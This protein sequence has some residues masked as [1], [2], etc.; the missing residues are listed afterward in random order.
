MDHILYPLNSSVAQLQVPFLCDG[1]AEYDA[2]PFTTYPIRKGW[3]RVTGDLLWLQCADEELAKRSQ[4]WLYFG[5]LSSFCGHV[6]PRAMLRESDPSTGSIRL[7]TKH[8]PLIL[9]TWN[10]QNKFGA[11]LKVLRT[12]LMEAWRLS[13]LVEGRVTSRQ[14][15]LPQISCSVRILLETLNSTNGLQLKTVSPTRR[16]VIGSIWPFEF[17]TGLIHGWKIPAAKAIKYRMDERGWCP[18]RVTDFS[19][20]FAGSTLH[21]LSGLPLSIQVSHAECIASRCIAYNIDES[22]YVP[23]HQDSCSRT[24]CSLTELSSAAVASIIEDDFGVPLVSCSI[25][26]NG[27]LE[28]KI[29]RAASGLNYVAISH[30]WSGG[31]G[32]PSRN[33]LPKCQVKHL[34]DRIISLRSKSLRPFGVKNIATLNKQILLWMDTFCIP[35]GN[36]Y[37]EARK[38]AISSM[39]EIY[40]GASAVLVLDSE[41]QRISFT[42][43]AAEQVLAHLLCSPWMSRCWTLQEASLSSSWY[44]DFEDGAVNMINIMDRLLR[45]SKVEFLI[46]HGRLESSMKRA[47]VQELSSSLVDMGEV[48][49]KRRGRYSRSEIWNLKQLEPLQAYVFAMTWNNFLGR[50]TSKPEDL[51]HILATLEDIR[52]NSIQDLPIRDRM[53]SILKCHASLPIDLLFCPCERMRNEDPLNAWVP[54]FPQAQSLDV[55]LGTMKLFTDC[56]FISKE[57]A[58][59]YLQ[60]CLVSST[61]FLSNFEADLPCIGRQWIEMNSTELSSYVN[62]ESAIACLIFPVTK[63]Q[64]GEKILFRNCGA[65]FLLRKQEGDDLHLIFDDTFHMYA[66]NR[67]GLGTESETY[68]L[69]LN[70]LVEPTPRI[71]I[72]CS[73]WFSPMTST[74]SLELTVVTTDLDDWPTAHLLHVTVEGPMFSKPAP[75]IL[76]SA[77][78]LLPL[79]WNFS[80][81][82]TLAAAARF[83]ISRLPIFYCYLG[84][85][86]F[87][88]GEIFWYFRV[89]ERIERD[90][91]SRN[92]SRANLDFSS[93]AEINRYPSLFFGYRRAAVIVCAT[94]IFLCSGAVSH[95]RRWALWFGSSLL[96]ECILRSILLFCWFILPKHPKISAWLEQGRISLM[97]SGWIQWFLRPIKPWRA[98]HERLPFQEDLAGPFRNTWPGTWNEILFWA[99]ILLLKPQRRMNQTNR[100][101]IQP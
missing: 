59:K 41:L 4:L 49:Y 66:Y 39:A 74:I 77:Y 43:M 91:W 94:L 95:D 18:A 7:S 76:F 67:S 36:T 13:E 35:V 47:L 23:Q 55:T 20:K 83:H 68:P 21:F 70:K 71:F 9:E 10:L 96:W 33:G 52:V 5:L 2:L 29:T 31:L 19:C 79:M 101:V 69:L 1:E 92:C 65:R 8:I 27:T 50:T 98:S 86:T 26:G 62:L 72:A 85:S 54:K 25:S 51:H 81:I 90:I 80:L 30:V 87:L 28:A 100:D 40:S 32:N 63:T 44:V 75:Y 60:I 93:Y 14:K 82:I 99:S 57:E 22:C 6:V 3:S 48:R 97:I 34:R 37:S 42:E 17:S 12:L 73:T 58:S 15:T 89:F 78:Q 61:G 46:R 38:K 84:R 16:Y 11:N 45:R 88:V 24:I 56:L 64:N 53:K